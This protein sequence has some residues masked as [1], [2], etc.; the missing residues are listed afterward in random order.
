ME[1]N[2]DFKARFW[3]RNTGGFFFTAE[4]GE[5]LLMR[6]KELYD[7]ATPSGNSVAALDLLR[8][9]RITANTDLERD[10]DL[11]GRTFAGNIRQFPSAY[12]QMLMATE[13][14][15]GPSREI[16]I[17]GRPEAPDTEEMLGQLRSIYLPNK[18]VIFR[19]TDETASQIEELAVY[20]KDQHS[21]DS[22]AT[23]YVCV[24]Y[25]CEL[26]T[27]DPKK[28]VDLLQGH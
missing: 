8:L 16:V 10:A 3:D 12:T 4:D 18:V 20:T 9:G 6:K 23:A 28:M 13:F 22:K 1:L 19:P 14:A 21:L 25:N 17:V 15:I 24:N 26:P 2:N 7:G 5:S 11:I 27:T